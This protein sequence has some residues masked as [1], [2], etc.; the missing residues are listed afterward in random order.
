[1]T[2]YT[3]EITPYFVYSPYFTAKL[4]NR[5]CSDLSQNILI[6]MT[7]RSDLAIG[8]K[9]FDMGQYRWRYDG[10][11]VRYRI[12]LNK[13]DHKVTAD[14]AYDYVNAQYVTMDRVTTE[15]TY[16][17]RYLKN[18]M[19]RWIEIRGFAG[20]YLNFSTAYDQAS[21]YTYPFAMSLSGTDGSQDIYFQEYYFGRGTVDGLW[22]QQRDENMGGFKSTSVFGTTTNWMA[23]S[24]LYFQLPI[25][26]VGIFGI[27]ADAGV[28]DNG[29]S[30]NSVWNAGV[31]MRISKVLGVYFPIWMSTNLK[32]SYGNSSYTE[33]IRFTLKMNIV[34]KGISL[35]SLF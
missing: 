4:G 20:T 14:I 15:A 30:L 23:T 9:S 26:K 12:D 10:Y 18:E 11:T 21:T 34:N 24:N 6:Q 33:K 5:K 25:P 19:K 22:S 13:P 8:Y 29:T 16:R 35:N 2:G 27:F 7:S 28:F 17:F 32:D 3:E 1:M 31:G